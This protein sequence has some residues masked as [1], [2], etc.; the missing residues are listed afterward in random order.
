MRWFGITHLGRERSRNED[1]YCILVGK[2]ESLFAVADGMGGHLSGNLASSLAIGVIEKHWPV[3]EQRLLTGGDQDEDIAAIVKQLIEEANCL[4]MN[5]ALADIS[6][7]GMGTTLSMGLLNGSSLTIGHVGDSR[8][9]LIE[10]GRISLL[11][12][13][14]SLIEQMIQDGVINPEEAQ[15]HPKRHILTRALGTSPVVEADLFQLGLPEGSALLFC[16]DGLTSLVN[17]E[18]ILALFLAHNQDPRQAAVAMVD[19]ANTRGGFDNIT[20]VMVTGIGRQ[21][22]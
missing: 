12:G 18:E 17:S 5:E 8:V 2:T 22:A 9:Y 16:T 13:D 1:S 3:L 10:S 21:E 15:N 14:H 4:I 6:H 11:T 20:V 19:L 7:K